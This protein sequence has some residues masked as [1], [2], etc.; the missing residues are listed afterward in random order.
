MV[1][2]G[3][4]PVPWW[5]RGED[6][7]YLTF[8]NRPIRSDRRQDGGCSRVV[9]LASAGGCV[10]REGAGVPEVSV[11]VPTRDRYTRVS[12]ALHSALW[13][14]EVDLEVIVVDDGS[15]DQT[16]DRVAGLRDPRVRV[17]RNDVPLG[18]S[19]ARNRGLEE[20]AAPWIAFLDDDDLW[21]PHKLRLQLDAAHRA[22]AHW[23]YGGDV[24]VD[25]DL[26]ILYGAPPPPPDEVVR[27]LHHHNS[28]PAGASNVVVESST[29]S[30]VGPFDVGL[31]R[32]AD[33]DMWLRLVQAGA[34][35]WVPAP[36]V[37]NTVHTTN[38]SRDMTVL[39]AELSLIADR[40]GI[41]VD[42]ARHHR[43]AAWSSLLE[44]RRGTAAGHYLKAAAAGDLT[45]LG[46]ALVAIGNPRS[47]VRRSSGRVHDAA[48]RLWM[49]QAR[50]W[51]EPLAALP[52]NTQESPS[53]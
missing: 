49:D 2:E 48:Q 38:M 26:N 17:L 28:V 25:E 5:H 44:G 35:A 30:R 31:R 3:E 12:L 41:A 8:L 22:D 27:Q 45:S 50:S 11:I 4:R 6:L 47:A 9:I 52:A 33:W 7:P 34:P 40:Y 18:E 24:I 51:L 29:L 37:A 14:R 10:R 42:R 46:R 36:L 15:V 21:A 23:V 53:R 43:W 32:T 39:F 16:A 1:A 20:A 19:G 13:Q